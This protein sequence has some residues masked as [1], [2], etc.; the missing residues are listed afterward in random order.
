M[1]INSLNKLVTGLL[2]TSILLLNC[3]NDD[4]VK[5]LNY[6]V[7]NTFPH[8]TDNF[9]QGLIWESDTLYEGTGHEMKSRIFKTNP[10]TGEIYDSIH[11][12]DNLFGEG[13]CKINSKI[14]QL[15]WRNHIVLV[16]NSHNLEKI[17]T[18]PLVTEG[19]GLCTDG[20]YLIVSDGTNTLSYYSPDN[21]EFVK[22]IFVKNKNIKVSELN[23][24]EY[25]N[26]FIYANQWNR[27][28]I[29]KIDPQTGQVKGIANLQGLFDLS[30]KKYSN[31][32]VLNGIAYNSN[33]DNFY[34]TGKYWSNLY[35]IKLTEK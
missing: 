16:Y 31:C 7:V 14:Y 27:N 20:K 30:R 34:V 28:L 3:Q 35:E 17:T 29:Y 22:K 1:I 18:Y 11:I 8:S 26:G 4:K 19:W 12:A 24:L 23:E 9:T 33:S 32:D 15:T 2:I 10:K 21:F 6:T 25:A 5:T 13:I